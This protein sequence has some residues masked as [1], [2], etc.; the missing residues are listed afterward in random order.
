MFLPCLIQGK[1]K[2]F[3]G[4]FESKI[5][6]I[7]ERNNCIYIVNGLNIEKHVALNSS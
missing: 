7:T 4:L 2:R 6:S 1:E 3:C 5:F